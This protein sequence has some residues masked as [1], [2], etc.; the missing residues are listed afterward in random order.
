M[1]IGADHTRDSQVDA[2]VAYHMASDS[3]IVVQ[4]AYPETELE[5]ANVQEKL[6]GHRFLS[7]E[8]FESSEKYRETGREAW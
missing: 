7:R 2:K 6:E 4:L 3:S 8:D 5:L 1:G